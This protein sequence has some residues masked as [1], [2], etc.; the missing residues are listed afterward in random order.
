M[1]T[2]PTR[3]A[4]IIVAFAGLF[5]QRTWSHAKTL[6]LGAILTPGVRTVASVL[7][8]LGLGAERHFVNYHRVLSRAAWSPRAASRILLGLLVR[9]FVPTG[10]I[11]FGIDDTIER[12]RGGK[13]RAKGIYRD[14]V[15]S[16]D[17][18]FVKA[19]GLR[20]LS[21]MLLAPIPW[22]KRTW[23][24]PVLTALAPSERYAEERG[25]RHKRLT[26]WARQLLLQL[27][28]WLPG[29]T[30]I[31]VADT[32][33]AALELL[34]ALAPHV[35]C[36]VRFRLD[37]QLYAPPSPP[38]GRKRPR[39]RPR[40]KGARLPSLHSVLTDRTTRWRRVTVPGWYGDLERT[41]ALTSGT[42]LWS[43]HGTTLPIRWVL[44][45]DPFG[46]FDPQAL[47]STDV[48]LDPLA[49]VRD[50]VQRWQV[51]VTFE[52]AR[53]HLGLE[54]QRQWSD[55]AIARTT[56]V[57]LSLFSLVTLLAN[58]LVRA[59]T[60]PLQRTAWYQKTTPTFSDALAAVRAELW[61]GEGFDIS[62]PPVEMSKRSRRILRR[63]ADI[64]CRVA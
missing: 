12:R 9:T 64:L 1:S 43:S 57:L 55:R 6:L 46:R 29:R 4:S 59:G 8:V 16:S 47:L 45:R 63:L 22:A 5:R 36:I 49:I 17:S 61:R 50:F 33:F 37:A 60:L 34:S 35:T 10:P 11:V 53:R 15:H 41:I 48:T 28:R 30:L 13:I 42:A 23:A 58:R 21:V 26:D 32:T 62:T 44:V 25:I 2:L 24:L 56:P 54:T 31:L 3:F 40:K 38:R 39:G 52:E 20:W 27:G 14:P 19:S 51:E 7:R 18:H